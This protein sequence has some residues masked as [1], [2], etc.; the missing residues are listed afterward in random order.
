MEGGSSRKNKKEEQTK[1]GINKSDRNE[2]EKKE[3]KKSRQR[4]REEKE[5]QKEGKKGKHIKNL[6]HWWRQRWAVAY[7]LDAL[8]ITMRAFLT[9]SRAAQC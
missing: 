8:Y 1:Y 3:G 2:K 7:F 5:A 6:K 9:H 4:R